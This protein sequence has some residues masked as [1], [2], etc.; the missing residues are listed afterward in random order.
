MIDDL[1]LAKS[2]ENDF[3]NKLHDLGYP[4]L[5][6]NLKGHENVKQLTTMKGSKNLYHSKAK[7]SLKPT[8]PESL[9]D[10]EPAKVLESH[11]GLQLPRNLKGH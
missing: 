4:E 10:S 5:S 7:D 11:D 8:D 6:K 9:K 1:E 2:S 3:S